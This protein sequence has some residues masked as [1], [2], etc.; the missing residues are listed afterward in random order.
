MEFALKNNV[1]SIKVIWSTFMHY[2]GTLS[3]FSTWMTRCCFS[4]GLCEIT[5]NSLHISVSLIMW[6][7]HAQMHSLAESAIMI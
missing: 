4:Q 7:S 5:Q 3:D 6:R 1:I 2:D